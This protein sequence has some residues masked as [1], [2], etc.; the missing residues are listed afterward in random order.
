MPNTRMIE[1]LRSRR[2]DPERYPT[3]WI[4]ENRLTV[5]LHDFGGAMRGFLQYTPDAPKKG[6]I[7][8]DL[9]YFPHT[10]YPGRQFI[11]GLELP[12]RGHTV[13]IT[14]SIFKAAALHSVGANAWSMNGSNIHEQLRLQMD[15]LPYRYICCGDQDKPGVKF[16][17]NFRHGYVGPDLDEQTP[18][19][20]KRLVDYYSALD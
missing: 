10:P 2:Y 17:L 15:L 12:V 6:K 5:P 20:L 9:K 11:W 8:H 4:T 3:Q 18:E 16:A 13:F 7:L 19:Q 14:E 1:H